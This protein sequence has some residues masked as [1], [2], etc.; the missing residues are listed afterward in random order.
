MKT[1]QGARMKTKNLL[2]LAIVLLFIFTVNINTASALPLWQ[3][4]L[5]DQSWSEFE[6]VEGGSFQDQYTVNFGNVSA[7]NPAL[8]SG[9]SGPGYMYIDNPYPQYSHVTT[10]AAAVLTFEFTLENDY[11]QLDLVYGRFGAEINY[12]S[13]DGNDIFSADGTAEGQYDLFEY[14]IIGDIYAGDH[15]LTLAY[16]G[17]DAGNGNFLDFIRLENGILLAD[18][19][20]NSSPAPV[21]EPGTIFLL[22]TGIVGLVSGCRRKMKNES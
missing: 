22:G 2:L 15:T 1:K 18:N 21:P 11:R 7:Q 5:A 9:A 4:G 14:A 16:G 6:T 19:G 3:Y 20:Q 17:G 8:N 12:L 13:F 10:A